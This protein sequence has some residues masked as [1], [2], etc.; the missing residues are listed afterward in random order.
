MAVHEQPSSRRSFRHFF[1]RGLAIVL[2]TILTIWIFMAA[3]GFVRDNIAEP[4]NAG[5]RELL[6]RQTRIPFVGTDEEVRERAEQELQGNAKTAWEV[7]GRDALWANLYFRRLKLHQQWDRIWF[8]MDLIGL[9]IAI[10][11]IYILG[12][13]VG[14][15]IG[16]RLYRRGEDVLQRTPVVKQVY[17]YVKQVTDFLVGTEQEKRQFKRVVAVQYPRKGLW[18]LGLVTGDAMR[19]I[20]NTV[21]G[22]MLTVFVPSSPTPFTGYVIT[23]QADETIDLNLTIEQAL[24]FTVSGGVLRPSFEN[25]GLGAQQAQVRIPQTAKG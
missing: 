14:S 12:R 19:T 16:S 22:G 18:S 15:Y 1:L 6:V 5:I 2:P 4:I 9:F 7:A 21:E 24:K 3:Y 25:R 10:V 23:V 13:F 8:P 20:Q 11:L 17:P